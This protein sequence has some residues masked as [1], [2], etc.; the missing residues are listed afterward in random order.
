MIIGQPLGIMRSL[1]FLGVDPATGLYLVSDKDGKPTST[2][3]YNTDRTVFI[4][5]LPKFYGGLQNSI[6]YKGL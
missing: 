1:H 3:D 2:P 5:T 6:R 4:N